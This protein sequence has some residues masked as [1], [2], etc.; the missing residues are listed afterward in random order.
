[1]LLPQALPSEASQLQLVDFLDRDWQS[2]PAAAGYAVLTVDQVPDDQVW[3]VDHMVCLCDSTAKTTFRVYL[4][5]RTPRR[6]RDGSAS[7]GNFDVADWPNGLVVP[8]RSVLIAEW[9]GATNSAV[10]VLALQAR[11]FRR[12]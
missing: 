9:S 6:I 10:G 1:M 7:S 2:P 8:S 5:S 11:V 3:L 12:S 4:D